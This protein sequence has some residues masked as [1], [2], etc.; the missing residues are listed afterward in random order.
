MGANRFALIALAWGSAAV[1]ARGA[2]PDPASLVLPADQVA[3]ARDL[4]RRLGSDAYR[5]RDRAMLEL[6]KMGRVA[7]PALRAGL[8]EPDPEVQLRTSLLVPRAEA[9]DLQAKID[10]FL[11]DAAGKYTH[12]LPAW[13]RFRT[14]A[15]DDEPAKLLFTEIVKKKANYDLLLAVRGIP[16]DLTQGAGALVG[17]PAGTAADS[18]PARELARALAARRQDFQTRLAP[19]WNANGRVQQFVPDVADVAL[20]MIGESLVPDRTLVV[21]NGGQYPIAN[22]FYQPAGRDALAGNGPH[23]PAFRRVALHWLDTREGVSGVMQAMN[24]AQNSNLGPAVVSKLAARLLSVPNANPWTKTYAASVL[25]RSNSREHL[26]AITHLFNDDTG[27]PRAGVNVNQPDIQVK[28]AALAMVLLLTNQSPKDYGFDVLNANNANNEALKYSYTNYRFTTD[29]KTSAED[30]R[31][32]AF[33]K[34]RAWEAGLHAACAGG[35]GA[36]AA[37]AAK[38]PEKKPADAAKP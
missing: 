27:L 11:A 30:K 28:D 9:E 3:R 10:T 5:E 7:L 4:V 2:S 20:V 15:G 22:F 18:P 24:V 23:G 36:A 31:A 33:V 38:Y 17:G 26:G 16:A 35:A 6:Q 19:Q 21:N 25:A 29:S 1:L 13:H 37:V 12:D 32:A 34:W 8:E 14:T